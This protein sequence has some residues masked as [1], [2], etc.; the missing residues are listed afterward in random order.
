MQ[1]GN[2]KR[3]H[4]G[5]TRKPEK[6]TVLGGEYKIFGAGSAVQLAN[7]LSYSIG[8]PYGYSSSCSTS[9]SAP[10]LWPE[11]V[12]ED[13]SGPLTSV[14]MWETWRELLALNFG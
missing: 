14:P 4:H 2:V 10:C 3:S 9:N 8:I 11:K 13:D 6:Q 5:G 7:P 12:V 1:K